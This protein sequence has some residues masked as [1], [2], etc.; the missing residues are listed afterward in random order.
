MGLLAVCCHDTEEN[1]RSKYTKETLSSLKETVDFNKHR[2]IIIDNNSC[3][4]NKQIIDDFV[5]STPNATSIRLNENIGTA[6]GI[7][8][9]IRERVD[10]E[11]VI[12]LDND[13]VVHQSGWVE[14]MERV[15]TDRPEIGICGLK[16]DDVAGDFIQDGRLLWAEDIMG[17]CTA[18]NPLLLDKM[19][20]LYQY[21]V[22][23]F[24]DNLA[25]A[26]SIGLGFKNCYLPLITI[27]HLDTGGTEYTKWKQKEAAMYLSEAG[28]AIK[29]YK[30]GKLNPYYDGDFDT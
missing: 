24:E 1:G 21:G 4:E 14:E 22:Y 30:E 5:S 2:I 7:N 6:A 3:L 27:T 11:V 26:R 20:Y 28:H 18:F 23:G 12:K 8:L 13:V 15:I 17:T 29:L 25:S 10:G 16:R 19:G 9:A